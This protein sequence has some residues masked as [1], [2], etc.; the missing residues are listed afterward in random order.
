[1]EDNASSGTVADNLAEPRPDGKHFLVA[2]GASAGGLDALERLFNRLPNNTGA[3]FV[4]IQHLSPDHKSMM[5]SLLARHTDMPVITVEDDMRL[6]PNTVFLIPPGAIMKVDGSHLRLTPKAPRVLTLPIDEFFHSMA[7]HYGDH[8]IGVVLSGTGAD[9]TRGAGAINEAGGFLIAQD[10]E[11]ARFDGMPRS[12]VSTGLVD[13]VLPVDRISERLA[14]HLTSQPIL[15]SERP[16]PRV[17]SYNGPDDPISRIMHLLLRSGG[18]NF[19]DYKPGTV[20]RRIERRMSVRQTFDLEEYLGLLQ[21]DPDEQRLLKRELLIPVTSFF[22]D[23]EAF[24]ALLDRV[25]QPLVD[26][27]TTGD[28]IRVWSAGTSTGEEA[29]S[30]AMMFL[31]AFERTKK[32]P[33]FKVFATDVEQA[34]VD[35]ASAGAYPASIEAE[36]KPEL[37]EKYFLRRGDQLHV[38]PDLR[39]AIVFARHNLLADPPFTRLDLA[40]CRNTLIYFKPAAQDRALRKLQYSLRIGGYLF[41][42]SSESLGASHDDFGSVSQRN[43]I[44]QKERE[45]RM[46]VRDLTSGASG[47]SP[48]EGYG[49]RGGSGRVNAGRVPQSAIELGH[50]SLQDGFGP[51][52]AVLVNAKQEII[53]SYGGAEHYLKVREGAARLDL[54]RLLPKA[55]VPVASAVLFKLSRTRERTA[56]DPVRFVDENGARQRVRLHAL[57]AG[58]KDG[59]TLGLLVFETTSSD[60]VDTPAIAHVSV[61]DA[62]AERVETLEN[63]LAATRENLQATIEELEASNEE[64]QATNEEMMASNEELQSSNEELQSVN[65]ELNTVNAEYQE[66]IQILNRLNADLDNLTQIISTGAIFVD[67]DLCVTRFSLGTV[68]IFNLRDTDIGRPLADLNH[69]LDYPH[70]VDD[71]RRTLTMH[72]EIESEATGASGRSYLVKMIPYKVPSSSDYGA[73]LTFLDTTDM[74]AGLRL[75]AVIDSLAEH[76][77]VLDSRG[78]IVMVNHAWKEFARNASD[79]DLHYDAIGVNYLDACSVEKSDEDAQF[80]SRARAGL[81]DLLA[82]RIT[83]FSMLYPCHGPSGNAWFVMNARPLGGDFC[84]AVVSHVNV[85]EW[86]AEDSI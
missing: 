67:K 79:G 86:R 31:E 78:T 49:S 45:N 5:A 14:A 64:L 68:G 52:P 38:R 43:K 32:W 8:A 28:A 24:E 30:L 62:A 56:S 61:D 81:K 17:D 13:A 18:V 40:T 23:P 57:P 53:H 29:Y 11:D 22:R 9:G 27:R 69:T 41:L 76:I 73:V 55:L 83:D 82:G 19:E 65:E 47:S 3:A 63:E 21:S 37:V 70:L 71:L 85:T 44:W 51:P 7:P 58:E 72:F 42:G 39:Q 25:V 59:E 75:Q 4:V 48:L 50:R 20:N 60:G 10:P 35:L 84:G 12:V 77:A 26:A 54:N 16:S 1:M 34:N 6:A 36:I 74:R 66:K 46:P 33:Q 80:A 15:V 2:I